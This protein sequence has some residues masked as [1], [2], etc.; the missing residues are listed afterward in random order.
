MLAEITAID[1]DLIEPESSFFDDLGIE[2][3]GVMEFINALENK[4]GLQIPESDVPR[5]QS[6]N[7]LIR[8]INS[9]SN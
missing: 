8:Y 9:K 5:I 3:V 6:L 4:Y 1:P 7:Q 2:T